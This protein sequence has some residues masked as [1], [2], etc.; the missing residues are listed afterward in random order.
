M[1]SLAPSRQPALHARS[2]HRMPV[3]RIGA[4][5][6][7]HVRFHHRIEVLGAG[8]F[9]ERGL[10]A[11]TGRRMADARA[12]IDVVVAEGRAHQLLHQIGFLVGAAR[13]RDAADRAAAIFGL[14]ALEFRSRMADRFVPG[15]FLP[16]IADLGA[17]HWLGDAV[18]MRGIPEGEAALDAGM[19]AI[20]LAVLVRHHAHDFRA[21]HFR[22]ER[23]AHAAIG[24]GGD[25]AVVGLT[26][27]D[28][29]FFHQRRG[30]AGL[31]AGAAGHAFRIHE[32]LALAGRDHGRKSAPV[33]G[34]RKSTL[35]FLAGTHTARADDAF[36]G[37]ELEIRIRGI[38]LGLQ[39]IRA[40]VA[41]TH[42]AQAHHAGHVL[43]FAITVGRTSQTVQRMVRDVQLHHVAPQVRKFRRLREYFHAR[44]HKR[45][46]RRRITFSALDFHQ[47]QPAGTECFQA[48]GGA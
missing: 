45:R 30:R 8:G 15:H 32:G 48:I 6:H 5:D 44:C 27:V 16:G 39:M 34:Q 42:L 37:I 9:A 7:H 24:A 47:A 11:I 31:H 46:A 40:F 43:Q 4:D 2:K 21:F 1:I 36:A 18:R 35:G 28:D 3:G 23:A 14:D 10:Q 17:D 13:R 29:R 26:L 33:D 38:D 12:G 19:P 22:A 41:V 20:G 25:D